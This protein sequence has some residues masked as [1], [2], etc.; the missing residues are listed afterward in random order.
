LGTNNDAIGSL[1]VGAGGLSG[2]DSEGVEASARNGGL[3]D[4]PAVLGEHLDAATTGR[5][6]G[7]EGEDAAPRAEGEADVAGVVEVV[8]DVT[9][10]RWTTLF[11]VTRLVPLD[12]GKNWTAALGGFGRMLYFFPFW[13]IGGIMRAWYIFF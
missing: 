12:G 5:G 10:R 4:E 9:G 8:E 2:R 6:L 7:V 1:F 13:G 11:T 3:G